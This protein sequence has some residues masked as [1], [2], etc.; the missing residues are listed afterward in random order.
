MPAIPG[1]RFIRTLTFEIFS[2]RYVPSSQM[3]SGE[4]AA[5]PWHAA[6]PTPRNAG[7]ATITREALLTLMTKNSGSAARDFILID[8]RRTDNE[9][10]FQ[11]PVSRRSA[12]LLVISICD[13]RSWILLLTSLQ[14]RQG[15]MIRGSIN[16]PAQSLYPTIPTLY[17]IFKAAG[18]RKIIWF[19][20]KT[21][22]TEEPESQ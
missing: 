20:C 9:V 15:G 11:F 13:S 12:M 14:L 5:A 7:P 4:S 22:C 19:C 17:S 10:E 8:L 21:S 18:L 3:A 2:R 16:L 6:Y 1:V